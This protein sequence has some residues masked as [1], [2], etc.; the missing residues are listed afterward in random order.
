[1]SFSLKDPGVLMN[2]HNTHCWQELSLQNKGGG[3]SNQSQ[4]DKSRIITDEKR[5]SFFLSSWK[6]NFT[7]VFVKKLFGV[8][9]FVGLGMN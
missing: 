8:L 2:T 6:Y 7:I 9:F 4:S 1:M 3:K 5:M